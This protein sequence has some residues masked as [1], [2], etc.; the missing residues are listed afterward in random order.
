M[1]A[2]YTGTFCD[3]LREPCSKLLRCLDAT[4]VPLL[5]KVQTMRIGRASTWWFDHLCSPAGSLSVT[6]SVTVSA[7]EMGRL[8]PRRARVAAAF[9]LRRWVGSGRE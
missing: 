7:R 4:S 6:T 5:Q 3:L 1:H 2:W 9:A 8:L